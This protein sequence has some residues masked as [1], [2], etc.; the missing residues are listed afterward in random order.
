ML[1]KII[2]FVNMLKNPETIETIDGQ[3]IYNGDQRKYERVPANRPFNRNV[4]NVDSFAKVVLEEVKRQGGD[5][6]GYLKTV[7][8]GRNGAEFF[9]D[10]TLGAEQNKWYFNR[11]FTHL[12]DTVKELCSAQ[13]LSHKDLL[14]ELESVKF[15]IEDFEKLY[16][17][18]S[19][20][21]ASK[22]I[23]FVSN[24]VFADGEQSGHYE[25]EQKIDSNGTTE[26]AV[27]PSEIPFRGKI[28]RGSEIEYAFSLSLSPVLN[29]EKGQIFFSLEMPGLDMV[30]DQVRE[31]EYQAFCE[32]VKDASELLILRNY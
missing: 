30:I 32:L 22:K 19:R 13:P 10:D 9:T 11:E 2:D 21:R 18:I 8:F 5:P 27:C 1:S 7:I 28:V 4:C 25:W 14:R 26:R 3:Y 17:T 16:Q 24:P 15:Y 23:S 29:E 31:D 12:W 6:K 20:L